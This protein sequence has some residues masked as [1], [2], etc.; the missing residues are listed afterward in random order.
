MKITSLLTRSFI[1]S[2]F[3]LASCSNDGKM[4]ESTSASDDA[5]PPVTETVAFTPPVVSDE[6]STKALEDKKG[7]RNEEILNSSGVKEKIPEK[8]K[9]T[10]DINITV[11]DYKEARTAI[12]NIVRSGHGY[13]SG[14]NEQNN[15]YNITNTMII[16]VANKQFEGM[17]S[18]LTAIKGHVNSRNVYTEDVT[19]EFVDITARLKS[20]KEVEK[21]YLEIL[22][23]ANKVSDILEVEDQLRVIREEIE[24]KEGQLKYLNDQVEYSTINLSFH[25]DF[26]YKPEDRPG[27]F[28]R[29][30]NAFGNGW[31]GFLSFLVGMMYAWPLWI[32]LSIGGYFLYKFV[33]R[34]LK[35]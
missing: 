20:K 12:E 5:P 24:A 14:E 19:A 17:V 35:K 31:N 18:N 23:K 21:R 27:F 6:E 25:Q 1:I 10:A 15:T 9:K 2:L 33:K 26:E 8:I 7:S 11:D 29:M 4:K 30:G 22:Q 32:I 13:I 28:G 34:Q 16:R 3:S